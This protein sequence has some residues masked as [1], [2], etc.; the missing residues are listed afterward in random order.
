MI[1]TF[2]RPL[3]TLRIVIYGRYRTLVSIAIVLVLAVGFL[4]GGSR[5][6]NAVTG[7]ATPSPTPTL[8]PVIEQPTS[9]PGP[10]ATPTPRRPIATATPQPTATPHTPA[11]VFISAS[12][13]DLT[14]TA[15]FHVG[16]SK[17]WCLVRNSALPAGAVSVSINWW[18]EQPSLNLYQISQA[19]WSGPVTGSYYYVSAT[20]AKYRCDVAVDGQPFGSARF[21]VMP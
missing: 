5:M 6:L 17:I 4:W 3:R 16:A 19:P 7:T 12:Q 13:T 20:P 21:A 2:I 10:R 15:S 1:L 14:P 11:K 18:Q 8:R 9:T